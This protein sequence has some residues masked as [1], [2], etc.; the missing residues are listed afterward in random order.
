MWEFQEL[1]QEVKKLEQFQKIQEVEKNISFKSMDT[2]VLNE[3]DITQAPAFVNSIKQKYSTYTKKQISKGVKKVS[4]IW[5]EDRYQKNL[6]QKKYEKKYIVKKDIQKK[7]KQKK[8][9]QNISKSKI[10][11][12]NSY[13]L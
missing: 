1:Q 6:L 11:K 12:E 4:S 3:F 7:N 2:F 9:Q 5:S 13:S 10:E 8:K